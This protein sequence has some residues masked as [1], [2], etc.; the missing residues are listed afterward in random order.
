MADR[1]NINREER[2]GQFKSTIN[3][4]SSTVYRG[5]LNWNREIPPYA[6]VSSIQGVGIE[7]PLYTEV[8]SFQGVGIEFP[9]YTEVTSF[10]GVG[11]EFPLYTEVSSFQGVGIEFPLYTEVSS[12]Q[13]V[14]IEEIHWIQRCPHF[15]G[16]AIHII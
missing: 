14:G 11:I 4:C 1:H 2:V 5:V 6:E 3:T 7:F 8:S 9:L 12:F 16:F 10:Q 15:C 13:G